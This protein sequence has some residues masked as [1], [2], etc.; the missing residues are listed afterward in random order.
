MD[1]IT[2]KGLKKT[3]KGVTALKGVSLTI[4][5]GGFYG[6]LGPNG[7]GKTTL[8]HSICGL[9][10]Y[11][12]GS[13]TVLGHD[14]IKDYR[15]ARSVIG[16]SQQ[17]I[18]MDLYFS[19]FDVLVYQAGYFGVP[20]DK[21]KQRAETLLKEFGVWD[22]RDKHHRELS[23]G[24]KRKIEIAKALMHNPKVLILDEPTAGID[25]HT[26]R[27]LWKKIKELNERGL[28][29][30]LTTHYI[31]EAQ[32]LCDTIAVVNNGEIVAQEPKDKLMKKLAKKV[33]RAEY[34]DKPKNVRNAKRIGNALEIRITHAQ[35][36]QRI[37]TQLLAAGEVTSITTHQQQLEDIFLELV[38][39]A[40]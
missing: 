20:K 22:K 19:V 25:V 1:A 33:V 15:E 6:L 10:N 35:D 24:M 11:D 23:G 2:I 5:Q 7:A 9:T 21:A 37:L 4:K 12:A 14:V 34:S 36:E 26:R 29:V 3:Y 27:S 28:T 8:I 32:E 39:E 30:L 13:I 38:G 18:H 17:D 16:L 31:E 40:E